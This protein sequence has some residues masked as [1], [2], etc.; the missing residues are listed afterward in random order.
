MAIETMRGTSM[1]DQTKAVAALA[2]AF[3]RNPKAPRP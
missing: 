3:E 2:E 1:T